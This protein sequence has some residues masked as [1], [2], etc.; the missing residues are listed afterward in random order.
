M[1]SDIHDISRYAHY[2]MY[3]C[4][5]VTSIAFISYVCMCVK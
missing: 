1:L 2:T 3:E 4:I 5:Y